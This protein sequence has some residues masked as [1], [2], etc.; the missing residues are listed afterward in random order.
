MHA[1]PQSWSHLHILIGVFPSFGLLTALCFL[2]AGNRSRN[3][4]TQRTC[5][6]LIGLLAKPR[7]YSGLPPYLWVTLVS[8]WRA[9]RQARDLASYTWERDDSTRVGSPGAA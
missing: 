7:L 9:K 5:L 1:I 2:V 6:A 4:R 8:R 3:D